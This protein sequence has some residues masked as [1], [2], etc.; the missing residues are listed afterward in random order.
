MPTEI[1][2]YGLFVN[3]DAVAGWIDPE[4]DEEQARGLITP[5]KVD[6]QLRDAGG[7]EIDLRIASPG[8]MAE[9]GFTIATALARYPGQVR[10]SIDSIAASAATIAISGANRVEIADNGGM[11]FHSARAIMIGEFTPADLQERIS[12]I[13]NINQRQAVSFARRGKLTRTQ[14]Q[15]ILNSGRDYVVGAREAKRLGIVDGTFKAA[16]QP[17]TVAVAIADTLADIKPDREKW[18]ADQWQAAAQAS[19]AVELFQIPA[20]GLRYADNLVLP[21]DSAAKA[22]ADRLARIRAD[23]DAILQTCLLADGAG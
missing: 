9:A 11:M 7:D 21:A 13:E 10:A 22:S 23:E 19:D 4:A 20:G 17:E 1:K 3:D 14:W 6:K 15:A 12:Y 8:G 2:L 16:E 5:L 18:I